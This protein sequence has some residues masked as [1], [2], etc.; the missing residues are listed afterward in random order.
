MSNP[1]SFIDEVTEEVRRDKLYAILRKWGWVGALA[2]IVIVGGAA[3]NEYLTAREAR[4][5]QAT[6]DAIL[7]AVESETTEARIAAL[8]AVP[9]TGDAVA[10]LDLIKAAETEDPAAADLLLAEVEG[11][12]AYPALYRDLAT[13]KRVTL[14]NSPMAPDAKIEALVP[15]TRAGGPF[16]T[17]AEEQTALAELAMGD[18]E[19]ALT[20]LQALLQD[21]EASSDLRDRASQI[22]VALGGTPEFGA[23]GAPE[24]TN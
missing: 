1:D 15:L 18:T 8:E 9:A 5:A 24:T 4:E 12:T 22:I 14:A 13:M 20:R 16:R 2:V 10:V 17:L 11:N 3:V 19:A 6:G 21:A 23:V 7:T